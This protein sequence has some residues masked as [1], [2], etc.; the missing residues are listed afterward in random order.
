MRPTTQNVVRDARERAG[1]TQLQLANESGVSLG[2]ISVAERGGRLS[3]RSAQ[4]LAAALHVTEIELMRAAS[5]RRR[6]RTTNEQPT[7]V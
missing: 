5:R 3:E 4:R 1:L 6:A 7:A 2:T